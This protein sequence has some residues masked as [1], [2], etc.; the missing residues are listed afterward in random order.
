[1]D[2]TNA[3]RWK[4]ELREVWLYRYCC[5]T[6]HFLFV[7]VDH[8]ALMTR[9]PHSRHVCKPSMRQ[10]LRRCQSPRGVYVRHPYNKIRQVWIFHGLPLADWPSRPLR[11]EVFGDRSEVLCARLILEITKQALQA[12]QISEVR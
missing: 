12:L 6:A 5:C 4:A 3:L 9:Q 11:C 7:V 10:R 1:M 8:L 2:L